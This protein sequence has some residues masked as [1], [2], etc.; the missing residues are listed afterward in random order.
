MDTLKTKRS[1]NER[2]PPFPEDF[3]E[4]LEKLKKLSGLSW[5][6]FAERLSVTQRGL[7]KWRNGGPPSRPY[8]WAIIQ[9]AGEI[10]GGRE[11]ILHGERRAPE[12]G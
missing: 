6:K 7:A 12:L 10:P 4:R 9:L 11:L 8:L 2:P 1:K 3:G 5:G